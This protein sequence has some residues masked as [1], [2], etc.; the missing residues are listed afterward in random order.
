MAVVRSRHRDFF[1]DTSFGVLLLE[2][3]IR[4]LCCSWVECAFLEIQYRL[5][6][7]MRASFVEL[8]RRTGNVNK[9]LHPE[10]AT[11]CGIGVDCLFFRICWSVGVTA[12]DCPVQLI[13]SFKG[14]D[15]LLTWSYCRCRCVDVIVGSVWPSAYPLV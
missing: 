6:L 12:A 15:S 1:E 11:E 4:F 13:R 14:S 7:G 9:R 2:G 5:R 8:D 10:L 3:S